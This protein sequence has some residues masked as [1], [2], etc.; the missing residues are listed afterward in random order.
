MGYRYTVH[1]MSLARILLT[2]LGHSMH[3]AISSSCVMSSETRTYLQASISLFPFF[4]LT[5]LGLG[6]AAAFLTA[7]FLAA[8]FFGAAFF[9]AVLAFAGAEVPVTAYEKG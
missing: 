9:A 8:V 7:G 2:K 6:L 3:L 1:N 5:A 4:F